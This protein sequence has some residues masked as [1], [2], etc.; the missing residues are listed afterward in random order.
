MSQVAF[1]STPNAIL[2]HA[3]WQPGPMVVNV[4]AGYAN[5]L[6]SLIRFCPLLERYEA[7]PCSEAVQSLLT[8][9]MIL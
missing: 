5:K 4:I 1:A 8:A 7:L 2:G 9:G 6:L 3:I